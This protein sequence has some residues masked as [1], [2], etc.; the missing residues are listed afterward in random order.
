[1]RPR[2][3]ASLAAVFTALLMAQHAAAAPVVVEQPRAFGRVIGDRF[4]QRVRVDAAADVAL[5][6]TPLRITRWF[7][8]QAAQLETDAAG[9]RWLV[10]RYQVVNAPRAAIAAELPAWTIAP[11]LAVPAHT[12]TLSPLLRDDGAIDPSQ[13]ALQPERDTPAPQTI[14]PRLRALAGAATTAAIALAWLGWWLLRQRAD[15]RRPFDRAWRRLRTQRDPATPS[16]WQ[17]L[18]QALNLSAGWTV[19]AGDLARLVDE[20]PWLAALQRELEAFFAASSARFFAPATSQ[21]PQPFDLQRLAASLRAAE[22]AAP[23]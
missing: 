3:C 2:R 14:A 23:R 4:E 1:M 8:R 6:E 18:H 12:L 11:G 13:P 19:Q 20:Q 15:A 7:E 16:D 21:G 10:V 9:R 5:P 22:R 17:A